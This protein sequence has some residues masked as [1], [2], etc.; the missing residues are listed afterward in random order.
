VTWSLKRLTTTYQWFNSGNDWRYEAVTRA[1]KI[2]GDVIAIGKDKP[3]QL[4]QTLS[5]GE[6]RLEAV[7]EGMAPASIDFYSGYYYSGASADTPDTLKVALDKTSVKTG[8]TLNVKID[9]RFAG[10]ASLQVVGDRLLSSQSIDVPEGGTTVPLTVEKGWGTGAYVLVTDFKPIDVAAKRMPARAIGVAWFGIDRQE[11]TLDVK[12]APVAQMKPR[13]PLKVPVKIGGLAPG[14][15]AYVTVA[16]VDVGILNLTRYKPPEP[17]SFYYDQK[18]LTA[19]IRDLYGRLIDGMQGSRGR[20]RSGGDSGGEWGAPP[21]TQP[22]LSLFSG[23]VQVKDDGTAEVSFDIPAFN[24]TVRVMAVAWTGSK[25]GHA[26][27][28]VIV[29]DPLVIAGTLPRFLSVGDQSRFRLD[30][31]NAEAPPGDYELLVTI[32]GPVEADISSL[33]RNVT[34]GAAGTR[35]PV[36]I[37][38]NAKA[39]GK[40]TLVA[41]LTGPQGVDVDQTYSLDVLPANPVVTR[42]IVK[43]IAPNGGA[44]TVSN[45]LLAE[46]VAGTAA[47]ALS[48]GPLPELDAAGLVRDLDRYPYGCS[49]QTVSRA[50]PLLYLSELGAKDVTIE[51]DLKDRLQD[52][53]SRLVNRQSANGAFGLWSAGSADDNLWLSSFVTDFLL[54]AREK[55]FAVPEDA[56]VNAID[57]LKNTVGNAPDIESGKGEDIAYALYVLAR[58]GKAPMGDLKYLADTRIDDFGSPMA[59]AQIAAALA[60]LGDKP[61]ADQAFASALTALEDEEANPD[62]GYRPD[63]GSALRDASGL[64]ALANDTDTGASVIKA[65]A[66]VIVTERAKTTYTTTQEMTWMVLAARAMAKEAASLKLD[67]NGTQQTGALYKL[68]DEGE[69]AKP[70][71]VKNL[72]ANPLRAVIAVSGS[73]SA[74]E[75]AASNGLTIA[76]TY[77]TPA[78]DEVDPANV[79]QNSRMVVVL[80]VSQQ[81]G[82]DQNGNFLLVDA[83]PAGFEI[84][85]PALVSSGD[86]SGLAW[87]TDTTETSHAEFRDDRFIAAFSSSTAKLAYS[88]RAVAPGT[89][90][91]PGATVE[92]MYRPELN[93]RTETGTVTVTE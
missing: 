60:I 29:R 91:H 8:D 26:V 70:Y 54:R 47:L 74:A 19:E 39:V 90:V 25:V 2:A 23:L 37:P 22:P 52:A 13:Q 83:L 1:S 44:I 32:N 28:D 81:G 38:I 78:G 86:T 59:R 10:K 42:R 7:A 48:V 69:L 55:G 40:A 56:L 80:S 67:A 89:Y 76:R 18:R 41:E 20:I 6:Y 92:D 12:M 68:F 3:A 33:S 51:G 17:E 79:K 62:R 88:I 24:G 58:A 72:N 65:A 66:Q 50:L 85:N 93:A 31:I 64:L 43:E 21:P 9:S 63:Y 30:L 57:Y 87:L 5:W 4:S 61:R 45:D 49:E 15:R 73:P 53:V 16:A 36:N 77:Y 27:S 84:E 14:E 11:R 46:M 75:P 35:Q 82:G 34:V 71:Q